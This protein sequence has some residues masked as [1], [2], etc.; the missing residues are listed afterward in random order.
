MHVYGDNV[1]YTP[2]K[3]QRKRERKVCIT[4]AKNRERET[5]ILH[6]CDRKKRYRCTQPPSHSHIIARFI[7]GVTTE[8]QCVVLRSKVCAIYHLF[9][10]SQ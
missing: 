10:I 2:A 1:A 9:Y 7:T 8:R 6:T 3:P 5:C 4:L